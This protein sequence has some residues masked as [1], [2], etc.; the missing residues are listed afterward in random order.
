MTASRN[1]FLPAILAA[2]SEA[3]IAADA[4]GRILLLNEAAERFSGWSSAEAEGRSFTDVIHLV[5]E[6]SGDSL[7]NPIPRLLAGEVFPSET[8]GALMVSR[9]GSHRLVAISGAL[10]KAESAMSDGI[11]VVIR[12][13]TGE[14][15][16]AEEVQKAQ[17]LD[18]LA[19]MAG[20]IAHD[21]N[22]LLTGFFGFLG[23]AQL[24]VEPGSRI[25]ERLT[26]AG[27]GLE[28][29]RE[30]STKLLTF[31]RGGV[32]STS[33]LSLPGLIREAVRFAL[34]GSSIT[35]TFAIPDDLAPV[36][37]DEKLLTQILHTIALHAAGVTRAG[38][39]ISVKADTRQITRKSG[40]P[41]NTGSYVCVTIRDEGP[42]ISRETR[43]HLF[44]PFF[45]V[46]PDS[47]G[48]NL[49][50]CYTQMRHQGG[51][52]TTDA[53]PEG[54]SLY[55]IWL[56]ASTS[57]ILPRQHLKQA[58]A[59]GAGAAGPR[60]RVLVLDD[61]TLVRD[62]LTAILE[63]LGYETEGAATGEEA[64]A[65]LQAAQDS[66]NSFALAFLD[67]TIQGGKGARETL[68]HLLEIDPRLISVITSGHSASP[69]VT[70]C[71]RHGFAAALVK[72]FDIDAVEKLMAKL[73]PRG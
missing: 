22:N 73:L 26:Q 5:G 18:S 60:R 17:R 23:L 14:V 10:P 29:A 12:D 55:Q 42:N 72:P 20:G 51:L 54:G 71:R 49:A 19:R 52:L 61:E 39:S 44:D 4:E 36:K 53:A 63:R 7:G 38:G 34:C 1:E 3:I 40:L 45:H 65:R 11:V 70:D 25:A 48:F 66:G 27:K 15:R 47:G 57:S 58:V 69:F 24:E 32:L 13:I 43:Q 56:P 62:S 46:L 64:V 21:F 41:L 2:I 8:E 6:R 28:R 16:Q 67:L 33:R 30:L 37:A 31:S 35:A 59:T 50:F 9:N 68:P